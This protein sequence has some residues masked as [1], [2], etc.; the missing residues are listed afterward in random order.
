MRDNE[1]GGEQT[2]TRIADIIRDHS[3]SLWG[4]KHG[5]IGAQYEYSH[6]LNQCGWRCRSHL[7]RPRVALGAGESYDIDPELGEDDLPVPRRN[8]LLYD[9]FFVLRL[10]GTECNVLTTIS[11]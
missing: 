2:C 3:T 4:E 6:L 10:V 1:R 9:W 5:A 8:T 7:I 11:A